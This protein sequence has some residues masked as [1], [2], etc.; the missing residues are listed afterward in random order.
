MYE[1]FN[2]MPE[3]KNSLL[4]NNKGLGG[5]DFS[6]TAAIYLDFKYNNNLL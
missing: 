2:P 3:D 5:E 6:W 1:Y 4:E